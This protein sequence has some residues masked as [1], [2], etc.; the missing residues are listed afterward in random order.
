MSV[1]TYTF[2]QKAFNTE[3]YS[4]KNI[5]CSIKSVSI[6]KLLHL[7]TVYYIVRFDRLCL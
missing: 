3:I 6:Q 4:L 7:Y 5:Y 2:Q 1:I